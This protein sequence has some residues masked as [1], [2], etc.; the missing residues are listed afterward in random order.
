[1]GVVECFLQAR[2]ACHGNRGAFFLSLGLSTD[3]QLFSC[4]L[5]PSSVSVISCCHIC[6]C[7][8]IFILIPTQCQLSAGLF[9][10]TELA[11][12]CFARKRLFK[13]THRKIDLH[14][15]VCQAAFPTLISLILRSTP[16]N[17]SHAPA[18]KHVSLTSVPR[19]LFQTFFFGH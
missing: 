11:H 2:C 14:K 1:M 19:C 4:C 12:M 3:S 13:W 15:C 9:V 10:A 18:Q 17:E 6:S 16:K 5:L 8:E 7:D